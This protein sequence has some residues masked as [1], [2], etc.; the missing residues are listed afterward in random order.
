MAMA[1]SIIGKK[2]DAFNKLK[3]LLK[4]NLG[5]IGKFTEYLMNENIPYKELEILYKELVEL[6]NKQRPIDIST[7]NYEGV[8]DK[9]QVLKNDI[10]INSLISKFPSKQKSIAKELLKN[11]SGYNIL[12][13]A[14]NSNKLEAL[15]TKISRYHNENEL[16]AALHLFGKEAMNNRDAIREFLKES[17]SFIVYDS[18]DIMIVRVN[19]LS[20]IQK[21]GSD[22]SW[23]IL[24]ESQWRHYTTGRYQYIIYDFTKDDWDPK[25]KIG[26]TLNKD[27]TVYTAHD[28]LDSGSSQYLNNLV[29]SNN[30]RYTD[31]IPKSDIITVTDEM[32]QSLKKA[33]KISTLTEYSDNITLDKIPS[34]LKK[35]FDISIDGRARETFS[36]GVVLGSTKIEILKDCLNKYFADTDLVTLKDLEK[37]D[38]RIAKSISS[39]RRKNSKILKGKLATSNI[40]FNTR[41]LSVSSIIKMLDVWD[42]NSLVHAFTSSNLDL[43]TVP[44]SSWSYSGDTLRWGDGW[45]KE[46]V[47]KVSDKLNKIYDSGEWEKTSIIKNNKHL[48][49]AFIKNYIILNYVLDREN[50]VEKSLLNEL[51][52]TSKMEY[53]FI[54]KMPID[55]DL[56]Q[57]SRKFTKWNI[58]LIIKKDYDKEL[59][60]DKFSETAILIDHLIGYKLK[61]RST[62]TTINKIMLNNYNLDTPGKKILNDLLNKLPARKRVGD[63]AE[64]EDG[65][66]SITLY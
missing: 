28:I 41:E 14:S 34:F 17:K 55:L 56:L 48:K 57:Y 44:G 3:E 23:C 21:L 61:F 29:M 50:I 38:D 18:E 35:L 13:K 42:L 4:S 62:K 54:F 43:I 11:D 46:S 66:I 36:G 2:M 39:L 51:S 25:F 8:V 9:I 15:L 26:F 63:K 7:L 52:E 65:K 31:L 6:K 40:T 60:I 22:T 37:I 20:D 59:S 24:R 12:L 27:F 19:S 45:D 5:Y 53:A 64:T 16:K 32:I 10:S 49:E 47:T 30:I 1:K 33:T 58:P